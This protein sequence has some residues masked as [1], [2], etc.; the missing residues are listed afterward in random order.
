VTTRL[1]RRA[2]PTVFHVTHPKAGSQWI[3]KILLACVGDRVV[4]P[5]GNWDQYFERPL[6]QGKV[7]PAV[8]L[9]REQFQ[10]AW[11]PRRWCRFVVVRDLRD[12]LVSLYFSFKFS[13]PTINP[14]VTE[15]RVAL[16]AHTEEEGLLRL[17]HQLLP[18]SATV[19]HSWHEAGERLIRYEDLLTDD[20]NI[21]GEVLLGECRLDIPY[22]RLRQAVLDCRFE[23][24]TQG[25]PRGQEDQFAH[26]RKGVVGDW[27]NHFTPR[28]K[29]EFKD[30]YGKLM[31]QTGYERDLNW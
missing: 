14:V 4:P 29:Q 26:E 20:L 18:H 1:K 13:H 21:L 30:I 3:H 16:R 9:S 17:M 19:H 24:L 22:E 23:K 10:E 25:R 15:W 12:T 28:V 6:E 7:Y 5:E 27:R 8:Y 11:L 31:V 2:P